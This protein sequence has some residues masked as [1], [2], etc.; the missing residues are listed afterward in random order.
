MGLAWGTLGAIAGAAAFCASGPLAGT[1]VAGVMV[2]AKAGAVIGGVAGLLLP[3]P[4][5]RTPSRFSGGV[6]PRG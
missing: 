5:P 1:V 6:H 3:D 2:T 4:G